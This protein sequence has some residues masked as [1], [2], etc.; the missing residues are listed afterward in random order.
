M[1]RKAPK[2]EKVT[3]TMLDKGIDARNRYKVPVKQWRKWSRIAR[4]V[5][6]RVY[7]F[8]INNESLLMHPKA[9]AS[10][11]VHWKTTAWN[12][13]WVAADAVDDTLPDYVENI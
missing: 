6:N 3:A 7:N 10:K 11:P 5:F 8:A 9:P 4:T 2:P 13:A 12:A 1:K